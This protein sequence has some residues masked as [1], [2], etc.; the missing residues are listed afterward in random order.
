MDLSLYNIPNVFLIDMNRLFYLTGRPGVGKSTIILKVVENLTNRNYDVGGFVSREV[1][2]SGSRIGFKVED[3]NT[4]ESGWLAHV[5]RTKGPKVGKY[6]VDIRD[7]EDVGVQALLR[8]IDKSDILVVDEVGPMELYSKAF[9]AAVRKGIES[10]KPM[11]GTVHQRARDP[12]IKTI[13]E[14][15]SSE[16]ITV[17][18]E[19]REQL[20]KVITEKIIEYMESKNS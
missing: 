9:K 3:L 16:I 13:K 15:K 4:G 7:L 12:L 11:L 18:Q 5:D 10:S 17:T 2:D 19:N 8:A 1:R 14:H 6:R 20:S